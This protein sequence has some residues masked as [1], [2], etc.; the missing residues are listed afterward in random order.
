[1]GL[2]RAHQQEV[3]LTLGQTYQ[4]TKIG[5]GEPEMPL[6]N[7]PDANVNAGLQP[8][9]DGTQPVTAGDEISAED[10]VPMSALEPVTLPTH[11]L[12]AMDVPCFLPKVIG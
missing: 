7:H 9:Q 2:A 10:P 11:P 8:A 6:T 5:K 4:Q 12:R 1:M 3:A